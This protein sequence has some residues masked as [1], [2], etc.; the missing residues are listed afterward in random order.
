VDGEF[1]DIEGYA[2]H[3]HSH[4]KRRREKDAMRTEREGEV[5]GEGWASYSS[6]GSRHKKE[7][8][9]S[10]RSDSYLEL[11]S[12]QKLESVIVNLTSINR[13]VSPNFMDR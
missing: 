11:S 4:E 12:S 8:I 7:L 6:K 13:K 3:T 5:N 2:A 9:Y 1:G 10:E